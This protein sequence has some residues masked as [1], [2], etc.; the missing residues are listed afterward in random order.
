MH[1]HDVDWLPVVEDRGSRRVIGVIRSQR[2][3]RRLVS[4]MSD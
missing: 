4:H 3:L 1:K 2:M